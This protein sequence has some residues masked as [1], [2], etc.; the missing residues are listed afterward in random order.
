MI[1]IIEYFESM[2][3][4]ID[5]KTET[6]LAYITAPHII[7]EVK[8][9]RATRINNQRAC[10]IEALKAEKTKI[11]RICTQNQ[12]ILD[13]ERIARRF[14]YFSSNNDY[15]YYFA[16]EGTIDP[17][18]G[19]LL[20]F[21]NELENCFLD[22]FIQVCANRGFDYN[23]YE[24][25]N[26]P[27][28]STLT[29]N[30][31]LPVFF[32]FVQE[33]KNCIFRSNI[34]NSEFFRIE[35]F[36]LQ[37]FGHSLPY[38]ALVKNRFLTTLEQ[39]PI[40]LVEEVLRKDTSDHFPFK[41]VDK[42]KISLEFSTFVRN[43]LEF[44]T[45]MQSR[46]LDKISEI[47]FNQCLC[48]RMD[49]VDYQRIYCY[50]TTYGPIRLP[51]LEKLNYISAYENTT[52]FFEDLKFG[53]KNT[54][55]EFFTAFL[56][57]LEFFEIDNCKK[58]K[59]DI[60]K[61]ALTSSRNV[62]FIIEK[63]CE[64]ERYETTF[65]RNK[66]R[67]F[68]LTNSLYVINKETFENVAPASPKYIHSMPIFFKK[69]ANNLTS[70][71]L[72]SCWSDFKESFFFENLE[73]LKIKFT[74]PTT[75]LNIKNDSM[76]NFDRLN[77]GNGYDLFLNI[78]APKLHTLSIA[79]N[80]KYRAGEHQAF[81]IF[82][83]LKVPRIK[84][85]DIDV[86]TLVNAKVEEFEHNCAI[87][88]FAPYSF[89]L[90]QL[91]CSWI[92]WNKFFKIAPQTNFGCL[93]SLSLY[94]SSIEDIRPEY[95]DNCPNLENFQIDDCSKTI[96]FEIIS[97]IIARLVK[98]KKIHIYLSKVI[99]GERPTDGKLKMD[100]GVFP[101]TIESII[102]QPSD[103]FGTLLNFMLI[104]PKSGKIFKN[105]YTLFNSG[106]FNF[107]FGFDNW[108]DF[109]PN[110]HILN[111]N[112]NN[113]DENLVHFDYPVFGVLTQLQVLFFNI[114]PNHK[115]VYI[116]NN[117]L[118][119]LTNLKSFSCG[120][121]NYMLQNKVFDK[122]PNLIT[123]RFAKFFFGNL[124]DSCNN[125]ERLNHFLYHSVERET[126]RSPNNDFEQ[127]KAKV[128]K[129]LKKENIHV[130]TVY[131]Y[132]NQL[133]AQWHSS[134][135]LDIIQILSFICGPDIPSKRFN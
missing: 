19:R 26:H 17:V 134:K 25:C 123:L 57:L 5:I 114:F 1:N 91:A 118:N 131:D 20:I 50:F 6:R 41:K 34:P 116:G 85:L 130:R 84:N 97:E 104:R 78:T 99:F 89:G 38:C 72:K 126:I 60:G 102:I 106:F 39:I 108:F 14:I 105:L 24:F 28:I 54:S 40:S 119:G 122:T 125:L 111:L 70:L 112:L 64:N 92:N 9:Q 110:L 16:K 62:R 132:E 22:I 124:P 73:E 86:Y 94:L 3:D 18:V 10:L 55:V 101:E 4:L 32:N 42:I 100:L 61:T 109:C 120:L 53:G 69:I 33:G 96:D 29:M 88:N 58:I 71:E 75:F 81:E 65:F 35:S 59:I 103:T 113:K 80:S 115:Q 107:E 36:S 21:E 135:I 68:A 43:P 7:D 47:T 2:I 27:K 37:K 48:N 12:I 95:F 128:R 98:L 90:E 49:N 76:M 11:I 83:D 117:F 129:I 31:D 93:K 15:D 82:W 44:F 79:N 45:I 133:S 13:V 23:F 74:P 63:M 52:S 66:L 67:K 127:V 121:N 87:K 46:G 8:S 51:N 56:N 30:I 77:S